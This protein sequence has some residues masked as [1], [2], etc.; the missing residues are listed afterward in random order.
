MGEKPSKVDKRRDTKQKITNANV[1]V[2]VLFD[3]PH[4]SSALLKIDK[5]NKLEILTSVRAMTRSTFGFCTKMRLLLAGL[6]LTANSHGT[7]TQRRNLRFQ[8]CFRTG[9][10]MGNKRTGNWAC[11]QVEFIP[12]NSSFWTTEPMESPEHDGLLERQKNSGSM[13]TG[14]ERKQSTIAG[15]LAI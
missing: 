6:P 9:N 13:P 5:R 4:P 14:T 2:D 3:K 7:T 11:T 12:D 15:G 8:S 1:L 10:A